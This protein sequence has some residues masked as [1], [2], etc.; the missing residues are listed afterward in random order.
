[1]AGH[2]EIAPFPAAAPP[3]RHTSN[4]LPSARR[5]IRR[6]NTSHTHLNGDM[7]TMG[8]Y[9][10]HKQLPPTHQQLYPSPR[11]RMRSLN[12]SHTPLKVYAIST[13]IAYTDMTTMRTFW[14]LLQHIPFPPK[15]YA[16]C[17]H[18]AYAFKA[19]CDLI[20][21]RIRR[22]DD[23]EDFLDPPEP[24]QHSLGVVCEV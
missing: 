20:R 24:P 23:N 7:T 6:L 8:I 22:Y 10:T 12:T 11:K 3:P 4:I 21:D 17:K 1:M 13:E 2:L 5:R 14:A 9:L 19:V 18:F 16:K 15:V